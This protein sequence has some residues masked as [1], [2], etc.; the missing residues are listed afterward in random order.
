MKIFLSV[1]LCTIAV[2]AFLPKSTCFSRRGGSGFKINAE[3]GDSRSPR[4]NLFNGLVQGGIALGGGLLLTQLL[5]RAQMALAGGKYPI[6]APESI[7]SEKGHGSSQKPVQK[8]LRW[9]CDE[10]TA[11]RICNFNRHWAE[12]AGYFVAKTN[13]IQDAMATKGE[14]TFYDSVTGKPLFIAPRG[15]SMKDFISESKVHG[16]PSFRDEEVVSSVTTN[17]YMTLLLCLVMMM[18]ILTSAFAF[19]YVSCSF[20]SNSSHLSSSS[21]LFIILVEPQVWD[22]VRCLSNGE[23]VSTTGTHLGHD[24][25]D[26]TGNRYCINLVSVAGR[27]ETPAA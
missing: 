17:M 9:G 2:S 25:P 6:I 7:M 10:E 4:L 24:L 22:N 12:N 23:C 13:F 3:M 20:H 14:I 26:R 27:P 21:P 1:L 15:R 11:D 8:N 5:P 16:W 18:S 19:A